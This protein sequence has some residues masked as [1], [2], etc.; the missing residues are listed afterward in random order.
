M[1]QP[2]DAPPEGYVA[3]YRA[4]H[5]CTSTHSIT[6]D[7]HGRNGRVFCPCCG[8][9]YMSWFTPWV[10]MQEDEQEYRA[11]AHGCTC[12]AIYCGPGSGHESYCGWEQG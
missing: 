6:E 12:N 5:E 1:P 2:P 4:G 10:L 3:C 8:R 11:R 7:E 9:S